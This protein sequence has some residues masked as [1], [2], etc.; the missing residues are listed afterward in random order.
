VRW[1]QAGALQPRFTIHSWNSDGSCTEPWTYPDVLPTIKA[2]LLFRYALMPYLYTLYYQAHTLGCAIVRPLVYE[3]PGD[4][5]CRSDRRGVAAVSLSPEVAHAASCDFLLGPSIL[6]AP[7]YRP[8]LEAR[9]VYL[10]AGTSWCDWHTGQWVQGGQ[11]LAG[12]SA[13]VT[14]N[15]PILFVRSGC[16]LLTLPWSHACMNADQV[17]TERRVL[18]LFCNGDGVVQASFYEDD[19]ESLNAPFTLLRVTAE[20]S[21]SLC[22]VSLILE[23]HRG[24]AAT[25]PY[26]SLTVELP[27]ADGRVVSVVSTQGFDASFVIGP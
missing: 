4:P 17:A 5:L 26:S 21:G 25:L 10:P 13:P 22:R 27:Q 1:C 2:I 16:A 18:R 14:R 12:V 15:S 8:G 3:F 11:V 6:V 9:D 23:R 20:F 24:D 19:G 7:V